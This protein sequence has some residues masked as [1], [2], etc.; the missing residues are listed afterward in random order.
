MFPIDSNARKVDSDVFTDHLQKKQLVQIDISPFQ[1]KTT[2]SFCY[3]CVQRDLSF[4]LST[5]HPTQSPFASHEI[6]LVALNQHFL[7]KESGIE[8]GRPHGT[9]SWNYES[10][11]ISVCVWTGCPCE[12]VT[13]KT[14]VTALW[15]HL[16]LSLCSSAFFPFFL[17]SFILSFSESLVY[18]RG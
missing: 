18:L 4:S 10:H 3:V 15:V 16:F 9:A 14:K 12:V 7:M 13:I 1:T 11:F 5:S 17:F 8:N 6:N 2:Y